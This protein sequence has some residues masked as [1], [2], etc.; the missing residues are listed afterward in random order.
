MTIYSGNVTN[1]RK[2]GNNEEENGMYEQNSYL[3]QHQFT[4]MQS[5]NQQMCR[6]VIPQKNTQQEN[7]QADEAYNGIKRKEVSNYPGDLLMGTNKRM[8]VMDPEMEK[9]ESLIGGDISEE[10]INWVLKMKLSHV[11]KVLETDIVGLY[12]VKKMIKDKI[13]YPILRPDLH[14]GLHRAPKGILFFGPPGTGKTTLAKWI[15]SQ[16]N[17]T[18]F[19]VSPSSITSKYHGETES[20]IRALFMVAELNAPS[21]LFIDEVDSVLAK[22][23]DNDEDYSIRMK[24]QL[25]QMMD[26]LTNKTDSIVIVVAATNRPEILDDAGLRRFTRRILIPLPNHESRMLFI[27]NI[28]TKHQT[29]SYLKDEHL[30]EISDKTE[31]WSGSDLLNLCTKAAEFS[32]DETI[33]KH[34]GIENVPDSSAFRAISIEDLRKSLDHIKPSSLANDKLDDWGS[35]FGSK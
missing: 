10:I 18:F 22:R 17:A 30:A 4:Q 16:S 9:Y 5:M 7:F 31:G 13:I 1:G 34:G 20:I 8:K 35:C 15:A 24:T 2:I 28:L 23:K 6:Q 26:G 12:D 25:L 21:V 27:R 19:E 29:S 14:K 3:M 32:Y 11:E 33:Q